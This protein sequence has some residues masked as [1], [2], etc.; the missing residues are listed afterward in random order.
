MA[1]LRYADVPADRA[2]WRS[3]LT[4]RFHRRFQAGIEVN[5]GVSEISPLATLFVLTEEERRPAVFLGTSS[6]RI[7]SPEGTQSFYLTLAKYL[8]FTRLAP[9]VSLNYSGWDDRWNVPFGAGLELGRGL[10]LRPMY[11]GER[12]HVMAGFFREHW[13]VSLLWV[14]LEDPGISVTLGW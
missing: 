4:Y 7:G 14:W 6:D 11:D 9:Y 3:T 2:R 12:S 10:Y 1:S 13:G 5:P 8:P